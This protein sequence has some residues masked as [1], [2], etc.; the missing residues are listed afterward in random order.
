M[1]NSKKWLAAIAVILVLA[2]AF[3]WGGDYAKN[4]TKVDTASVTES[5]AAGKEDA[6]AS[7]TATEE[8]GGEEKADGGQAEPAS[9]PSSESL[10]LAVEKPA[11]QAEAEGSPAPTDGL[12]QGSPA[13]TP[14][15]KPDSSAAPTP[16]PK[17]EATK[18]P[19]DAGGKQPTAT[20]K[21]TSTPKGGKDKYQTDPI[22]SGKPKPVEWQDTV[23]D[24]KKKLTATLSVSAA[25][26]LDH[27]DSFNKDKLE[28]LPEDGIIY[29]EQKVT[30]Y[31][32]ESV[33]DVLLR[34]MK[35]NKIHMEFEMTP[36]YNSNYIEGI[37][38][39]YEFDCGELSGWMFKVNGWFPNY[40]A[41]RYALKDGDKIEWVYT[42]D[43]G[44]DVGGYSAGAGDGK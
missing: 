15:A 17:P 33:F 3:F 8:H 21:P 19:A 16:T 44:R 20:I 24:K 11:G 22:P 23:V 10:P 38:N 41:S 14:P 18:K 39:I 28:V 43:L 40:G 13:A 25:S 32:G 9:T 4:T 6:T 29:K 26:I 42:C 5:P 37:N 7:P 1:K 12:E 36:I 30:F 34:E 31:E 2:V 35:K 27:M